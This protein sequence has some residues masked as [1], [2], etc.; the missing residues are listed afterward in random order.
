[1]SFL[2]RL[3]SDNSISFEQIP[4]R[5]PSSAATSKEKILHEVWV[6]VHSYIRVRFDI[7]SSIDFKDVNGF[8]KLGAQN[9]Y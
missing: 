8:P 3:V 4:L 1:M 9:P 5:P 7:L 2:A 6:F